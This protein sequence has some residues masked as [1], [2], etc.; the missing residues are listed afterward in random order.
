MRKVKLQNIPV[1]ALEA[2]QSELERYKEWI[3]YQGRINSKVNFLDAIIIVDICFRLWFVLRQRIEAAPKDT[4]SIT[5]KPSEAAVIEKCC[6]HG[7]SR[8][9]YI[10]NALEMIKN[11]IDQQLK[12]IL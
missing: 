9:I 12:S 8:S 2:L 6:L 7:V 1:T 10:Q 11:K 5:L 4:V 3:M